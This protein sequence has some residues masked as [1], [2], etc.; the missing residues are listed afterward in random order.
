MMDKTACTPCRYRRCVELLKIQA[1]PSGCGYVPI[2]AASAT[3]STTKKRPSAIEPS[4]P[5]S[6]PAIK[7]P[8]KPA[9]TER[10]PVKTPVMQSPESSP[11]KSPLKTTEKSPLKSPMHSS[12][13]ILSSPP[14]KKRGEFKSLVIY[15][16][17]FNL[18]QG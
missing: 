5:A 16:S 11:T 8:K 3:K 10:I 7:T 9:E 14:A 1:H 12:P 18:P 17:V 4:P 15:I 6:Q 13:D 2:P